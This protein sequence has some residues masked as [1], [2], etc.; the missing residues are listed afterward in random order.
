MA[1]VFRALCNPL[2][3][4]HKGKHAP[5]KRRG[6]QCIAARDAGRSA[7][8]SEIVGPRPGQGH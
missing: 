4:H 1:L 6:A 8:R 7:R 5:K 3:T 2:K